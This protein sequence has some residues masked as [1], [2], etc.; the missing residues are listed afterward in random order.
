MFTLGVINNKMVMNCKEAKIVFRASNE[1]TIFTM[2]T[3]LAKLGAVY[4][5]DF[6][7]HSRMECYTLIDLIEELDEKEFRRQ[8]QN[9][10]K[11]LIH[12]PATLNN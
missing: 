3:K 12:Y 1:N 10:L 7:V 8:L 6:A 2:L 4:I 5:S 9:M 11:P